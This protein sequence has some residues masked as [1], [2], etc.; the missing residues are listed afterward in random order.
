MVITSNLPGYSRLP[1]A[2]N[3]KL[4][5]HGRHYL[6]FW[7]LLEVNKCENKDQRWIVNVVVAEIENYR[8]GGRKLLSVF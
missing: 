5:L 7:Q 4:T 3:R 6:C 8:N 2:N 1:V